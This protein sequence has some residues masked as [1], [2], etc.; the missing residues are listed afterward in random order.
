MGFPES[1]GSCASASAAWGRGCGGARR[2]AG[3]VVLDLA[4]LHVVD[5]AVREN[6]VRLLPGLI[7]ALVVVHRD[8][9]APED[10]EP[11]AADD[12]GRVL[13]QSETQV[14]G[15]LL[16]H[17]NEIVPT[18]AGVDVLVDGGALQE[19]EAVLVIRLRG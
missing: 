16:H 15:E 2:R 11:V 17:G 1:S 7:R 4:G 6:E 19:R 9:E 12:D 5:V 3:P 10:L 8:L 14:L 18:V 13:R